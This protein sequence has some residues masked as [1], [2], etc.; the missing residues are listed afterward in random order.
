ML[1]HPAS[2][3]LHAKWSKLLVFLAIV[4]LAGFNGSVS[5][6][7][8][9]SDTQAQLGPTEVPGDGE[10]P[11]VSYPA[12]FFDKYQPDTALDMIRQLPGF[13]LDD[14]DAKRGFG[15]AVGNLLI[16][17]RYVSAKQDKS[18]T[19]LARIPASRV[20]RIE[21]V[22]GQVRDIDLRGRP[23][24]ANVI[25]D[26]DRNSA[27]RW[28]L[29][30][31]KNFQMAALAPTGSVSVFDRWHNTDYSIGVDAARAAY[32]DPGTVNVQDG[33][34][35]LAQ[36]QDR[37]HHGTGYTASAHFSASQWQGETLLKL[38]T[39]IAQE[40]RKEALHSQRTWLLPGGAPDDDFFI[41][42][43]DNRKFELGLDAERKLNPDL[44]GKAILLFFRLD[45]T[46]FASQRSNDAA[47]NETLF[48]QVDTDTGS[49]EK[50]AR[51]EFDWTRISNHDIKINLEAAR[52]VLDSELEQV[53]D[54]GNG[55]EIASVPGANTRVKEVRGDILL[56][57]TWSFADSELIYGLG[58]ETSTISQ[59]GDT[60]LERKFF[61]LKPQVTFTHTA[62]P[63]RQTRLRV[64]REVSQL[65]FNDFVSAT[66]FED[67]D[68][69]LGNPDLRP[70]TTWL[71]EASVEH[72]FG[73]LGVV[74]LTAFHHWISDVEDLLPLS[75]DFEVPGNI[76][77]G[78]RWGII[79][80]TTL[81]LESLG[82]T[83]ARLN[84]KARWQNSVIEDPVTGRNRVLSSEGGYKG[85]V[86]FLNENKYALFVDFRQDF[87]NA[88]I[89]WGW[90]TAGRAKRPL[91]KVNELDVY[92]EGTEV[93]VF[94]E[95]TRW[96]GLKIR[97]SGLN[98]LNSHETRDRTVYAGE[99]D[100]SPVA[101]RELRALSSGARV[102]L[103][104]SGAF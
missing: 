43:R 64:A 49:S 37:D 74:K 93:N 104:F 83:G 15:A 12:E 88:Q 31:R 45:K 72:R 27:S 6:Q 26:E 100:L 53:V 10:D 24:V 98:L 70:E 40:L 82:L 42:N 30:L 103:S 21:L 20:A 59:S 13:R 78:R 96:L 50:I 67:D 95:T 92:A 76:G 86:L 46:P 16:N 7:E 91:F 56:S 3:C 38:N 79:L 44:T 55:P 5:A 35:A 57:D 62:S 47:G 39:T 23:V 11:V 102:L 73:P 65:D 58:A 29:A 80:E 101:F 51:L 48:R 71:A 52:N 99:R 75:Q 33:S 84:V 9:G 2:A 90:N 89:A 94:I 97:L 34:G 22:R 17:D 60:D 4:G 41:D 77:D 68:L 25:L 61:F 32:G 66:V 87:S 28:E 85:D 8:N 81:P 1:D 14:G 63:Q 36:L 54:T 18:S 19:I 69:A